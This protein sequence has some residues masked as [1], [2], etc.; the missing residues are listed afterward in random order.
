[1]ANGDSGSA[2]VVSQAP[3]AVRQAVQSGIV[4]VRRNVEQAD[5]PALTDAYTTMQERSQ[6]DN[7]SWVALAEI[8]GL[9]RFLCWHHSSIGSQRFPFDLFLPWH[10]AYLLLFEQTALAVNSAA[11]LPWWDWTSDRSH[12]IGIPEAFT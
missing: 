10:R 6:I 12:E 5:V 4:R 2:S 11:S 8:H 7:R 9:D 1:M 3:Q